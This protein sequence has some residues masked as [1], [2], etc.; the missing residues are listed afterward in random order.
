MA[1]GPDNRKAAIAVSFDN[2]GEAF[3]V[4]QG[5][6]PDDV[7]VGTHFTATSVLP[8]MLQDLDRHSIPA[9]FFVEGWN[10]EIYPAELNAMQSTGHEVGLHG[11][12]HELWFEQTEAERIELLDR[13]VA[14][15]KALGISPIGFRPPGGL[16]TDD[17][18]DILK[19]AGLRYVSAAGEGV[20]AGGAVAQVPFRWI[21]VDALYLEPQ[22]GIVRQALFGSD[23]LL[24]LSDW[25][26]A[27]KKLQTDALEQGACITL[28]FHPYLLGEDEK[29][30]EVFADFLERICNADDIWLARCGDIA[31]WAGKSCL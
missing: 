18:D 8:K 7:P 13:G 12:R 23:D 19:R 31:D 17:T 25:V 9:T 20:S 15:M 5:A 27:L 6:W 1:W 21:D 10:A 14:A 22:L 16:S 3:D 24:S 2:F 30:Y 28:I 4:E 11:W 29:R 26:A